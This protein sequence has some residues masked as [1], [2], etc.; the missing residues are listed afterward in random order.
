ME[1]Y[2]LWPSKRFKGSILGP[3]FSIYIYV[4]CFISKKT[5][6]TQ[7]MQMVTL[8]SAETN[9]ETVINTIETLS[10]VLFDWFSENSM[11]DNSSKRRLLMSDRETAHTNLDGSMVKSSQKEILLGITLDRELKSEDHVKLKLFA[12]SQIVPH[13]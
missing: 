1:R 10:L 6:T 13:S 9:W 5:L 2:I 8:F 4:I 7:V 11:K 3:L 12:L